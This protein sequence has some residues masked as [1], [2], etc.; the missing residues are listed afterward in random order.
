MYK[1]VSF[2]KRSMIHTT[3]SNVVLYDVAMDDVIGNRKKFI[4]AKNVYQ[5]KVG[6]RFLL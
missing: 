6:I 2:Q 1:M 5:F 4:V 3:T